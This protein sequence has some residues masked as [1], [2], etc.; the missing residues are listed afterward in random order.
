ME[1]TDFP[2]ARIFSVAPW[3]NFPIQVR[4]MQQ[5]KWELRSG[6]EITVFDLTE[7]RSVAFTKNSFPEGEM[8]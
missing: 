3:F 7:P 1:D 6:S 8:E 4:K 2:K 5:L